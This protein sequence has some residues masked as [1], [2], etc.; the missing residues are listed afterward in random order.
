MFEP[1]SLQSFPPLRNKAQK[2][3]FLSFI[4]HFTELKTYL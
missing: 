1:N 2:R 4:L 3:V